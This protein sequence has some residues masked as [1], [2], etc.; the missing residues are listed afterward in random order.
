MIDHALALRDLL[1]FEFFFSPRTDFVS[2]IKAEIARYSVDS[3]SAANLVDVDIQAMLPAKSP[4]VLR[5]F[6]EAYIVVA[7][8]LALAADEPLT[9]DDLAS[10]CLKMGEQMYQRQ[11]ILSKE[12]MTSALY[13]SGI[14]LVANRGLLDSNLAA[15]SEFRDENSG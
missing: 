2:E 3:N 10:R 1:K 8:T 4:F 15:R 13:A 12:A 5:P 9:A 14:Q 11:E 6:L 7:E